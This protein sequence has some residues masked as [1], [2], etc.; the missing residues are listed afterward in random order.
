MVGKIFKKLIIVR[1]EAIIQYSRKWNIKILQKTNKEI[2]C[3]SLQKRKKIRT[4]Y[5]KK[6]LIKTCELQAWFDVNCSRNEFLE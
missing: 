1:G 6:P 4:E 2:L 5:C 3:L